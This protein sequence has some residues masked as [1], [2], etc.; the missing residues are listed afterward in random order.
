MNDMERRKFEDSFQE[1]FKDAEINPSENVWTNI[2]LDLE[3]A[4]GDNMKRRIIFFKMLA[5]ASVV[6]ALCA[7]GL[8]YYLLSDNPATTNIAQQDA[9]SKNPADA[10]QQAIAEE[11]E[12]PQQALRNDADRRTG[13][14]LADVEKPVTEQP[15]NSSLHDRALAQQQEKND[16][17]SPDGL[18]SSTDQGLPH[19]QGINSRKP[20]NSS[21]AQNDV[22]DSRPDSPPLTESRTSNNFR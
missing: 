3:R 16:A 15:S 9:G 19:G 22:R 2:E 5:A 21:L 8:T 1:A 4:N 11:P 12:S 18:A 17:A 14:E 13:E 6:F 10:K 7:G 20:D